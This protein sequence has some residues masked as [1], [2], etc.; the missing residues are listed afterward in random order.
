MVFVP[1]LPM[2]HPDCVLSVVQP[3][4][5]K[6]RYQTV[7]VMNKCASTREMCRANEILMGHLSEENGR[8]HH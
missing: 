1:L 4:T 2:I 5:A 8:D 7:T 3:L 6:T